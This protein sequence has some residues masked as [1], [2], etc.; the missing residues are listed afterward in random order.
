M[1]YNEI[2]AATERGIRKY[3]GDTG[4]S[5]EDFDV[6]KQ[7]QCAQKAILELW[8]DLSSAMVD[9]VSDDQGLRVQIEAD[10]TRLE[11]LVIPF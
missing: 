10:D 11:D 6:Q 9:Q 1:T 4:T 7:A 2:T 8:R 3:M 5:S